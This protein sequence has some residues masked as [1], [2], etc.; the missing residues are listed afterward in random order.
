MFFPGVKMSETLSMEKP[1]KVL[2]LDLAI[3][4]I[5][6]KDND[7]WREQKM[8]GFFLFFFSCF[9]NP[10]SVDCELIRKIKVGLKSYFITLILVITM[11]AHAA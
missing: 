11:N 10:C 4:L 9:F 3:W 6:R 2:K 5:L 7:E 8:G 1:E